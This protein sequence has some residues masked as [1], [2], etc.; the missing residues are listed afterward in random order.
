[1][2]EFLTA[3]QIAMK[4]KQLCAAYLSS[5]TDENKAAMEA[6]T[7]QKWTPAPSNNNS[8]LSSNVVLEELTEAFNQL[9]WTQ[10]KAHEMFQH[11][12]KILE[13][14]VTNPNLITDEAFAFYSLGE[15][16]GEAEQQSRINLANV[17]AENEHKI[18]QAI[19]EFPLNVFGENLPLEQC[20]AFRELFNKLTN[21]NFRPYLRC[22]RPTKNCATCWAL[23]DCQ[24]LN[25]KLDLAKSS[26]TPFGVNDETGKQRDSQ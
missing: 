8:S 11:L 5:R 19:A 9:D 25:P 20:N 10:P 3:D 4:N 12:L 14:L 22:L 15:A 7:K 2:A 1:M 18:K 21:I 16:C 13:G 24:T 26:T 17:Q 6:F 23:K